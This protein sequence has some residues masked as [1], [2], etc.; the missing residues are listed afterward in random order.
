LILA[1]TV[2]LGSQCEPDHVGRPADLPDHWAKIAFRGGNSV[3]RE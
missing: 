1:E 2:R 3:D